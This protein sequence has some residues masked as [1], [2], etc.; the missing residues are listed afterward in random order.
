MK[1]TD[2]GF[3]APEGAREEPGAGLHPGGFFQREPPTRRGARG[4]G[5]GMAGVPQGGAVVPERD[6]RGDGGVQGG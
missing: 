5:Q 2:G 1:S 3:P 6:G 4:W